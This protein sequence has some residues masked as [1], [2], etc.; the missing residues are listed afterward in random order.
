MEWKIKAYLLAYVLDI[1]F[2]GFLF[3]DEIC[4]PFFVGVQMGEEYYLSK[5]YTKALT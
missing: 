5:D 4:H 1:G 2:L 3:L